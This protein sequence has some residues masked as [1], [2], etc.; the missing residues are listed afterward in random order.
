MRV[1]LT[2]RSRV[3][4]AGARPEVPSGR[5]RD[6]RDGRNVRF[7]TKDQVRRPIRRSKTTRSR[8]T[9]C[10][11]L[12]DTLVDY[13]AV[14]GETA[15]RLTIT[16]EHPAASWTVSPDGPRVSVHAGDGLGYSDGTPIVD[17][18]SCTARARALNATRRSGRSCRPSKAAQACSTRR[19]STA[20][21]G[22]SG[23]RVRA[24]ARHHGSREAE[25]RVT[26]SEDAVRGPADAPITS[27]RAGGRPSAARNRSERAFVLEPRGTRAAAS[28]W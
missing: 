25:R 6:A 11:A 1:L 21:G 23:A 14:R 5:E 9:W 24:R 19:P 22:T 20:A 16:P 2:A 28:W 7:A 4:L 17:A 3:R 26:T 18:T 15:S 8:A 27:R 12:F 13:A 10:H